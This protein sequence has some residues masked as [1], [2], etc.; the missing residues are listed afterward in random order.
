V[1]FGQIWI[2]LV[3]DLAGGF[4]AAITFRMMNP[5]DK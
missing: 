1:S 5:G 3:A 2:H 4:V